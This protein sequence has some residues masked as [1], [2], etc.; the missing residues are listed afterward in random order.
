MSMSGET[1]YGGASYVTMNQDKMLNE[2]GSNRVRLLKPTADHLRIYLP[3]A[4]RLQPGGVFAILK[5]VDAT[6][7]IHIHDYAGGGVGQ[8]PDGHWGKVFLESNHSSAGTWRL[9]T[10][11]SASFTNASAVSGTGSEA[12]TT[13]AP[14][15]TADGQTLTARTI[16]PGATLDN[17]QLAAWGL[18]LPGLV[19]IDLPFDAVSAVGSDLAF[20]V[21]ALLTSDANAATAADLVNRILG[22]RLDGESAMGQNG[23]GNPWGLVHQIHR[24]I[25][26]QSLRAPQR[27]VT[28]LTRFSLVLAAFDEGPDL[29]ATVAL[30]RASDPAPFEIIVVDDCSSE[31]VEERLRAFPDVVVLKTPERLGAGPAKSYGGR[32]ASGDVVVLMDAHLRFPQDWL[33]LALEAYSHYPDSVMCPVST[34]FRQNDPFIGAGARFC[35]R[36]ELG[37]DLSWLGARDRDM[38][39][40]IPAVLGGCYFIPRKIWES[41]GGLN[42]CLSGW[43]YEEQDLSLRAWA[44]GYDCRCI[45]GLLV[46]HNY[47]RNLTKCGDRLATW[48]GLYNGLVVAA[49]VFE[50]GVY[51]HDFRPFAKFV[52]PHA[53]KALQEIDQNWERICAF[54][55]T[56][57]V[58]RKYDDEELKALTGLVFP[59]RESM[60]WSVDHKKREATERAERKEEE[61]DELTSTETRIHERIARNSPGCPPPSCLEVI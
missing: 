10:T 29:E 44:L 32:M 52:S 4:S 5:N 13:P 12:T 59:N 25:E 58:Q 16:A 55:E 8:L 38:V 20:E 56:T 18:G 17:G 27:E 21:A 49:T 26:D 35:R 53:E 24:T 47:D 45:N 23:G 42:P 39:D 51:E 37:L 3:N 48:Q 43:G 15:T 46:Q 31:S 40:L 34:G 28:D 30:A 41:L 22:L 54:A 19:P 6:R 2:V 14:A 57:Q 36:G 33:R 9:V 61:R 60:M 7:D 50:E 1:F 11:D